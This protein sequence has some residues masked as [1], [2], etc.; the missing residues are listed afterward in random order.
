MR[1]DQSAGCSR[2]ELTL[3]GFVQFLLGSSW[4]IPSSPLPTHWHQP[5]HVPARSSIAHASPLPRLT[6]CQFPVGMWVSALRR[7]KAPEKSKCYKRCKN[8]FQRASPMVPLKYCMWYHSFVWLKCVKC[9]LW[10]ELEALQCQ[11]SVGMHPL[12]KHTQAPHAHPHHTQKHQIGRARLLATAHL[13]FDKNQRSP[14]NRI[15]RNCS[16]IKR[17]GLSGIW[18]CLL[19]MSK[20]PPEH[21]CV[22][23][24][25]GM[26]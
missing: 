16:E 26:C 2:S 15:F 10:K 18:L 25:G 9:G 5:P 24:L 14:W 8:P 20:E 23:C 4:E 13:I 17:F 19:S 12:S 7:N 22:Q 1:K 11:R 21:I 3:Y 6:S